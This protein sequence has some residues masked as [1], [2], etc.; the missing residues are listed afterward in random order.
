MNDIRYWD[1]INKKFV[2]EFKID[3]PP[4]IPVMYSRYRDEHDKHLYVG[5]IIGR[6]HDSFRTQVVWEDDCMGCF[7]SGNFLTLREMANEEDIIFQWYILGNIYES[8]ELL[9]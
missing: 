6:E 5:A 9:K 8:P 1:P 4:L 7:I 2:T 3:R